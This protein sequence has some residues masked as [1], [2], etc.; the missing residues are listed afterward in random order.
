M[1][2]PECNIA[3]G[4]A[5]DLLN[6]LPLQSALQCKAVY[7]LPRAP[8]M[9]SASNHMPTLDGL[10]SSFSKRE[11]M[12]LDGM[13]IKL[14]LGILERSILIHSEDCTPLLVPEKIIVPANRLPIIPYVRFH[15]TEASIIEAFVQ[16]F[17][18]IKCC[19]QEKEAKLL[20]EICEQSSKTTLKQMYKALSEYFQGES[21][22]GS[23][24]D[25]GTLFTATELG[26]SKVD[27]IRSFN[28]CFSMLPVAT[29]FTLDEQF[30]D[31]PFDN[32]YKQAPC[33]RQSS[34]ED[35]APTDLV[36]SDSDSQFDSPSNSDYS[37]ST[38][39]I[40][41]NSDDETVDEP[42]KKKV[43]L[44]NT[45]ELLL[46]D[47]KKYQKPVVVGRKTYLMT[48]AYNKDLAALDKYISFLGYAAKKRLTLTIDN[49]P[50][51]FHPGSTALM[52]AARVGF[53]EGVKLLIKEVRIRNTKD[54]TAIMMAAMG[55]HVSC[56]KEL[57][58]YEVRTKDIYGY[59][60]LMKAAQ[61]NSYDA[62]K[63]LCTHESK[64]TA[65]SHRTALHMAAERKHVDIVRLLGK[66]EAK[67]PDARGETGLL[68]SILKANKDMILAL[69]PLEGGVS[70]MNGQTPLERLEKYQHK[71]ASTEIYEECRDAIMLGE[72]KSAKTQRKD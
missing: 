49:K 66:Y 16:L 35:E 70:A 51:S 60:S 53:L 55:N 26:L 48:A 58:P 63:V 23:K 12:F 62:A 37:I 10:I 8:W 32:K 52:I 19:I 68:I 65:R 41:S 47:S 21:L 14:A 3:Q 72:K 34:P 15:C 7:D 33:S 38:N 11:M 17:K 18:C 45:Q 31:K 1:S 39:S 40:I 64:I 44:S 25:N 57:I 20:T 61:Y 29:N 24:R 46:A 71:F 56:V 28:T 4:S 22:C 30:D 50:I 59:T 67:I 54:E 13:G 5:N 36:Q 69:G 27:N 42:P 6:Q 2:E 43:P 9:I